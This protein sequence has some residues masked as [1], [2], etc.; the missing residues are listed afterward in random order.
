MHP[1]LLFTRTGSLS[2]IRQP[3]PRPA[4][5]R[6]PPTHTHTH[7][8]CLILPPWKQSPSAAPKPG[9]HHSHLLQNKRLWKSPRCCSSLIRASAVKRQRLIQSSLLLFGLFS[10]SFHLCSTGWLCFCCW[11]CWVRSGM[12][13]DWGKHLGALRGREQ[14]EGLPHCR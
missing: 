11:P 4:H 6:K 10:F 8:L 7:T 3:P 14:Q 5:K 9:D 2:I 13:H 1:R 12:S